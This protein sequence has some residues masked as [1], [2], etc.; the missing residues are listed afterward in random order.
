[1]GEGPPESRDGANNHERAESKAAANLARVYPAHELA[2]TGNNLE[3]PATSTAELT[4]GRF[5][6]DHSAPFGDARLASYLRFLSRELSDDQVPSFFRASYAYDKFK[7][8]GTAECRR[9][10]WLHVQ[11]ACGWGGRKSPNHLSTPLPSNTILEQP[12][13]SESRGG[14]DK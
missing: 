4:Q 3:Q 11:L 8:S 9:F 10:A 7:R 2:A 12:R 6:F 1:M 5:A 14:A 13:A